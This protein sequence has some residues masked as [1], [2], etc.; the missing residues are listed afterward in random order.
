MNAEHTNPLLAWISA[1]ET[2]D[3]GRL[4]LTN[5]LFAFRTKRPT[6]RILLDLF[7]AIS[8][9]WTVDGGRRADSVIEVIA[10]DVLTSAMCGAPTV[11]STR[12]SRV[13][14][15]VS[16]VTHNIDHEKLGFG[17]SDE[18][19]SR[20]LQLLERGIPEGAAKSQL[21]GRRPLAWVTP[22]EHL[23]ELR[24]QYPDPN[25]LATVVRNRLGLSHYDQDQLLL[26][27]EYPDDV[28]STLEFAAPT[29]LEG[30]AGVIFRA[31]FCSDS[32]GRAVNLETLGDGLPEAVH[33]PIPF[34]SRFRIRRIGRTRT[35]PGF[36]FQKVIDGAEYPWTEMPEDL[37][38]FLA[39]SMRGDTE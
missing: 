22:T 2:T 1:L 6:E 13:V 11:P 4:M 19:P 15:A 36:E 9:Q 23:D 37:N 28:V 29:F 35:D 14:D 25:E 10:D 31:R 17:L 5:V 18:V 39:V 3:S 8:A 27:V 7:V 16:L 20:L 30:G 26:E 12:C 33:R 38:A 32:W 34:S 24:Q 21:R